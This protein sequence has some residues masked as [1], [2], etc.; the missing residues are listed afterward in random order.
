[1]DDAPAVLLTGEEHQLITNTL[2]KLLPY[3]DPDR[4]T[5]AEVWAAYREAYKLYPHWLEA[6]AKYFR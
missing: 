3:G 2:R 5:K 4:Y 1:V 6:S